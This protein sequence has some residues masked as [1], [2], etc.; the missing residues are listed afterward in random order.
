M[1]RNDVNPCETRAQGS[2]V[3]CRIL[4]SLVFVRTK[5]SARQGQCPGIPLQVPA[6]GS[7]PLLEQ[8]HRSSTVEDPH[9]E[10][11]ALGAPVVQGDGSVTVGACM[12]IALRNQGANSRIAIS[13]G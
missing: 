4:A 12:G 5:S 3:F 7:S 13:L 2:T 1:V 8:G 6:A 9:A 11:G 10:G